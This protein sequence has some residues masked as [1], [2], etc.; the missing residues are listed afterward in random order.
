LQNRA[1]FSTKLGEYLASGNPVV[2]A[3]VGD[4]PLYLKDRENAFVY[5]PED[6]MAVEYIMEYILAHPIEASMIANN[7]KIV[8]A[9]HFNSILEAQKLIAAFERCRD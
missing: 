6:Y 4:I 8:A 2:A 3:G 9:K 7:G 5:K 1:G